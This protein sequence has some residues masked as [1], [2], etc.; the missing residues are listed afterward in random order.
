MDF[1][2]VRLV[3]AQ[4]VCATAEMHEVKLGALNLNFK[5]GNIGEMCK[6]GNPEGELCLI[7]YYPTEPCC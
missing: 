5:W 3:P 7:Q 1:C 6:K 4:S 2:G